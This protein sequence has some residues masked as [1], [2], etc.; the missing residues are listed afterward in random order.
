[1]L[2]LPNVDLI[3]IDCTDN[4][5]QAGKVLDECCSLIKFNSAKLITSRKFGYSNSWSYNLIEIPPINSKAEYSDFC[6]NKLFKY[7]STEF[8]FIVQADSGIVNINLWSNDFLHYDYIGAPWWYD[9]NKNVGNGGFSIRSK[10]LM[11][12]IAHEPT[13]SNNPNEDDYICRERYDELIRV[14]FTFA[15]ESIATKFSYE[16]NLKYKTPCQHFGYHGVNSSIKMNNH[17]N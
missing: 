10:A 17:P 5:I 8:V 15:P 14:G 7:I 6:I 13:Q 12:Y 3:C 11:E 16:G 1:V 9:D 4:Y 2:E